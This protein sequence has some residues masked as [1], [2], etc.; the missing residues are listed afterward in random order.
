MLCGDFINFI[1]SF[2]KVKK[3]FDNYDKIDSLM[4]GD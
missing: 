3:F 2:F 4:I 1:E